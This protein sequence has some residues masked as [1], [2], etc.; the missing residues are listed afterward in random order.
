M[1]TYT[2]YQN[3]RVKQK[4]TWY[5]I[6]LSSSTES[7]RN[8]N[9][10]IR[11]MIFS[12]LMRRFWYFVSIFLSLSCGRRAFQAGSGIRYFRHFLGKS[13]DKFFNNVWKIIELWIKLVKNALTSFNLSNNKRFSSQINLSRKQFALPTDYH[14][15]KLNHCNPIYKILN[16]TK[17]YI[18][19]FHLIQSAIWQ[20]HSN[21]LFTNCRNMQKVVENF[22]SKDNLFAFKAFK[23]FKP[24][25]PE[26]PM[27]IQQTGA[28][29]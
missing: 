6:T 4:Y 9:K 23:A 7:Q 25:N 10:L 12:L 29:F 26:N 5:E 21:F 16:N 13:C 27:H 15:K 11:K 22:S 20:Y 17:Q 8:I 24:A 18:F 2:Y 28:L 14:R 3:K 19:L 1:Y